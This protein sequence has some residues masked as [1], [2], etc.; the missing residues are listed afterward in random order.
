MPC[1]VGWPG[2]QQVML[3]RGR[4]GRSRGQM[5]CGREC[6]T[7]G[8]WTREF[9][10][11]LRVKEAL[12]S[13]RAR[14]TTWR[15]AVPPPSSPPSLRAPRPTGRGQ[16]ACAQPAPATEK[17][18]REAVLKTGK[19]RRTSPSFRR[20][21]RCRR[22]LWGSLSLLHNMP[23]CAQHRQC[24]AHADAMPSLPGGDTA[25]PPTI[26]AA[27]RPSLPPEPPAGNKTRSAAKRKKMTNP[28]TKKNKKTVEEDSLS[29][30][31]VVWALEACIRYVEW[32]ITQSMSALKHRP[33]LGA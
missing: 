30:L 8:L 33:V 22:P 31:T 28:S 7:P 5:R 12:L 9:Q 15:A 23:H 11:S 13:I 26:R 32:G 24:G 27:A 2:A 29:R 6:G 19:L 3:L 17:G 18:A 4:C 25:R 16:R 1:H 21:R 20:R 14:A 10:P